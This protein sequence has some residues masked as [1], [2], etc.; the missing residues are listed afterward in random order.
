MI[1]SWQFVLGFLVFMLAWAFVN[2]DILARPFDAF[3]FILL[4]LFFSMLAGF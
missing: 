2:M 3:P 1:G 4:D